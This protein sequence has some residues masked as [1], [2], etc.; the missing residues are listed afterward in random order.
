MKITIK[1]V[2]LVVLLTAFFNNLNGSG[3]IDAPVEITQP[4]GSVI[5]I[6]VIIVY[7]SN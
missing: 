5:N 2:I 7:R 1:M 4:D 6:L 3:V